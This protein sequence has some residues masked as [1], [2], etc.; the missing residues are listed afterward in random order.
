MKTKEEIV[1][2]V[3]DLVIY[4]GIIEIGKELGKR[5]E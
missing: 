4:Q 1:I 5:K 2:V 3:R